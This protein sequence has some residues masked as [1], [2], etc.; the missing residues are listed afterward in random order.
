MRVGGTFE[1]GTVD[2]KGLGEIYMRGETRGEEGE[3]GWN[4]M[5]R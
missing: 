1:E 2:G 3:A 4:G 5:K